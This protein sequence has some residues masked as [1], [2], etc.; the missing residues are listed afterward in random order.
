MVKKLFKIISLAILF[1]LVLYFFVYKQLGVCLFELQSP[2]MEPIIHGSNLPHEHGDI[3]FAATIFRRATLQTN[4]LVVVNLNVEGRPVTTVRKIT[5]C[6]GD[7]YLSIS[8]EIIQIPKGY[9]YLSAQSKDGI[10]SRK[11]GL[12][13]ND[14]V[15]AKVLYIIHRKS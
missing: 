9:V 6:A 7:N 13:R 4:D 1:V 2:S 11:L 5:G 15:R 8:N 12:F 10:V 3:V 14:Q